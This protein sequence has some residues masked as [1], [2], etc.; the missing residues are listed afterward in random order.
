[1]KDITN[2]MQYLNTK[3]TLSSTD[4]TETDDIDQDIILPETEL[5]KDYRIKQTNRNET[6]RFWWSLF[7]AFNALGFLIIFSRALS[8]EYNLL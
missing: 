4:S 6:V 5:E 3:D 1:M 8:K 2:N 7:A